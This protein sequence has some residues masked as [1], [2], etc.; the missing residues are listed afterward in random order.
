MKDIEIQFLH[1][2]RILNETNKF[3]KTVA[4]FIHIMKSKNFL[5]DILS[6]FFKICYKTVTCNNFLFLG[7][8][9]RFLYLL[10]SFFKHRQQLQRLDLPHVWLC[11]KSFCWKAN[12]LINND[13]NI[14]FK[15]K[16]KQLMPVK[17]FVLHKKVLCLWELFIS[18]VWFT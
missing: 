8:V 11:E 16:M 17:D 15:A 3:L 5:S 10:F 13:E 4:N 2:L 9:L 14:L 12:S 7:L 6:I 1:E 18:N